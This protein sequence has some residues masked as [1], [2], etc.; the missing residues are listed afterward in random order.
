MSA[1]PRPEKRGFR[2]RNREQGG[3]KGKM[4]LLVIGENQVGGLLSHITPVLAHSDAHVCGLE[5]GC[6]VNAVT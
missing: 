1:R 3:E 5:R 6:V 2:K 4:D